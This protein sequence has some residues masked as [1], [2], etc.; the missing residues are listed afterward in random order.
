[1]FNNE[2]IEHYKQVFKKQ[3]VEFTNEQ[4]LISILKQ[5]Y[6]YAQILYEQFKINNMNLN[7]SYEIQ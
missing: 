5:M 1:M 6:Q 4:E 2:K 3:K 7:L